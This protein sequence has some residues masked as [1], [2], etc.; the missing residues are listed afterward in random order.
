M[1]DKLN[2]LSKQLKLDKI[3]RERE[4]AE[5]LKD[6]QEGKQELTNLVDKEIE[7]SKKRI[8]Y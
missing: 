3:K 6:K 4:N 7:N 2:K 8:G 5:R 1:K